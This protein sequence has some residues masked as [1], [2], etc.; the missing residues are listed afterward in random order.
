MDQKQNAKSFDMEFIDKIRNKK[1][2][3]FLC[4][5]PILLLLLFY[6]IKAQ[7]FPLHDFSNYFFGGLFSV[8][9]K[10]DHQ[11]YD[12][13]HFNTLIQNSG[14]QNIF[15][16]YYPNTPFLSFFFIPFAA[17]DPFVA[18]QLF[19]FI[20]ALLFSFTLIRLFNHYEIKWEW[21]LVLPLIFFMSIKNNLL[22]GQVYLFIFFLL[23]EGF[24]AYKKGNKLSMSAFWSIAILL[25]VF[26]ILL[27]FFLVLRKDYKGLAYLFFACLVLLI[28]S[29]LFYGFENWIYFISEVMPKS[30]AGEIYD[31]FSTNS[32]SALVLFKNL[33]VADALANPQ[34]IIPIS[35]LF[36][37]VFILFKA[38]LLGICGAMTLKFKEQPLIPFSVFLVVS[39]L[40]SP[41]N[42]SYSKVFLIFPVL[43]LL[44]SNAEKIPKGILLFIVFLICNLPQHYFYELP[45]LLRFPRFY[46]LL[47][48]LIGFCL[49][50]KSK[51]HW[52]ISLAFLALF[53][54]QALP[55]II[56]NEKDQSEYVL[57]DAQNP[58]LVS[59]YQFENGDLQIENWDNQGK[60]WT[61]SG[62]NFTIK[63]TSPLN[64]KNNQVFLE[65][66]QITFG[67]DNKRQAKLINGNE[68][69]YLSDKN[70]GF[71]FYTL[72]RVEL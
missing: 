60:H 39:L 40:I 46:F 34:P 43:A 38:R 29:G 72:R 4:S 65:N 13:L 17:F 28:S 44:N 63:K 3:P 64:I 36:T 54:F 71:G 1:F 25:K 26:P 41:T 67:K 57:I 21:L 20:S 22:F 7:Y 18:K 51:I 61:N 37:L 47:A 16:S 23:G 70:R 62:I 35:I 2:F 68:V 66:K 12:A 8:L 45:L 6:W 69:W 55:G 31:G 19:N 33:F 48:F 15:A 53:L 32:K 59:N 50:F 56:K 49:V 14:Y 27:G 10:F 11:L 9:G 24:L 42:S 30:S 58:I 5:L 52:P